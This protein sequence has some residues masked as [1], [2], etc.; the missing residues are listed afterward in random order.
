MGEKRSNSLS[1]FIFEFSLTAIPTSAD[2]FIDND[3]KYA[4]H[5]RG[6]PRMIKKLSK[7]DERFARLVAAGGES[8]GAHYA[9]SRDRDY[10]GF[11]DDYQAENLAKNEEIAKAIQSY[12]R[13]II[14]RDVLSRQ[15][16]L[17]SLTE[18]FRAPS[19]P[20]IFL[21]L[22]K[23][24]KQRLEPEVYAAAVSRL[25]LA[26]IKNIKRTRNG[27]SVEGFDLERLAGRIMTLAGVDISKPIT[28]EGKVRA[29]EL[30]ADIYR[31]INGTTDTEPKGE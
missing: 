30:L 17:V 19:A 4:P 3:V 28:E 1:G 6:E 29:R 24:D 8:P 14:A 7:R 11:N 10:K 27:L 22:S 9:K 2:F 25:N 12:K 13:Q 23:L 16:T 15:E 5:R 26:G 18:R 21:E 20:E 31:D